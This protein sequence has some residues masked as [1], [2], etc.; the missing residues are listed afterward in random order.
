MPAPTPTYYRFTGPAIALLFYAAYVP[1]SDAGTQ[2][3][4]GAADGSITLYDGNP[5]GTATQVAEFT[6]LT[7]SAETAL[8][9][10]ILD[11][12]GLYDPSSS[13]AVVPALPAGGA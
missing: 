10:E 8:W 2:G 9:D 11:L 1:A 3:A 7:F 13:S 5:D 6:G 4:D 12:M